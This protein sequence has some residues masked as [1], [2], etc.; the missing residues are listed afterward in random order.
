VD[1]KNSAFSGGQKNEMKTEV[2]HGAEKLSHFEQIES[3]VDGAGTVPAAE[4]VADSWKRCT[5]GFH[6]D[7]SSQSAPHILTEGELR[8]SREPAGRIISYAQEELDR[9]HATL[10]ESGYVVLLCDARGVAI[11]HRGNQSQAD[12]FKHW[13][14]WVGGV[15]SEEVEGTNGIGTCITEQ[16]PVVVHRGQHYRTRHTEL[17]CSAAP[18]FDAEAKLVAVLDSSSFRPE[19]SERFHELALAATKVSARAIEERL[20]RESFLN[21]WTI[22]AAPSNDD[23]PA[24]LLAVDKDHRVI[25]ADRAARLAFGLDDKR[26]AGGVHLSILYDHESA[27]LRSNNGQDV[28]TRLVEAD[29]VREWHAVI[30][31]PAV[32]PGELRI[33]GNSA[34]HSR[35]RIN[36]LGSIPIAQPSTS[37][38]GGLAPRVTQLM[39]EYIESHLSESISLDAMAEMA[40]LSVFHFTRAF[41]RSFE[42]PPHAY[43]LHRRVERAL[44]L[45]EQTELALSEI[46]FST[47][48]SDQSHFAKHF[49]RITGVTPSAVRWNRR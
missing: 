15:W 9:L 47:G 23:G 8:A 27:M 38:H 24:L 29:G 11:H 31:P 45:L 2:K 1:F 32:G 34:Q 40:G 43:L 42:M 12:E 4:D 6:L 33:L 7:P 44:R 19:A 46:A 36:M 17:S 25:G 14:I 21:S 13:G 37:N 35:P 39:R 22:A 49:R 41:R 3:V 30:T 18:I 10:R 26:L 5:A 20:F 16:R 48:F 28:A